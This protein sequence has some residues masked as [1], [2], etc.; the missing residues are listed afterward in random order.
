MPLDELRAVLE[1]LPEYSPIGTSTFAA[2]V[3]PALVRG[4]GYDPHDLYFE[5]ASS[6]GSGWQ[7]DAV[8]AASRTTRPWIV[9]ETK[10]HH[11]R[12]L[13]EQWREQLAAYVPHSQAEFGVLVS[14]LSLMIWS[15]RQGE[16][17]SYD[18]ARLTNDSLRQLLAVLAP[19]SELPT[20]SISSS[21][22]GDASATPC[23]HFSVNR[24]E[25]VHRW[26]AVETATTPKD[27]GESLEALAALLFGG[28]PFLKVKYRRLTTS[29]SEIDIVVEYQGRAPIPTIFK[30]TGRY[31]LVE[32]KNWSASVGAKHVR[33]F[34][35]KLTKTQVRLG[36]LFSTAGITGRNGGEDA[37]REV[38]WTF[39]KFGIRVIVFALDHYLAIL[40]GKCFDEMIEE[41]ADRLTFDR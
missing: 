30:E 28:I 35:G 6:I 37:L 40:G 27:K 3:L 16:L 2:D 13:R 17:Y 12:I 9:F 32:C 34:V 39:D 31:A 41:E 7:W 19:P 20:E 4:L 1:S 26:R 38:K 25:L 36:F 15:Q 24:S 29:S 22:I 8:L 18:L 10:A 5:P 11:S 33:D 21:G 14:P 23:P